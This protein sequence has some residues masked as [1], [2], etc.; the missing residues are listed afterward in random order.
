MLSSSFLAFLTLAVTV[1]ANP[2]VTS[3]PITL[4]FAKVVNTTG[5]VN[6]IAKDQA[7]I[8]ALKSRTS[9]VVLER[10]VSDP[11]TNELVSYI[12]SVST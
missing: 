8:K 10:A 4:P 12:A 9:P 6:I 2:I 5:T 7:R 3:S 1:A 11:V